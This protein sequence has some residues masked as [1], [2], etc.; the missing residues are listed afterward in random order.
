VIEINLLPTSYL[1]AVYT[2]NDFEFGSKKI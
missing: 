2:Q 1:A